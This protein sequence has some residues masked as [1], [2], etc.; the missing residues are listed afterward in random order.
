MTHAEPL[1]V[2]LAVGG[3]IGTATYCLG[4]VVRAVVRARQAQRRRR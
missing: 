4:R 2:Q 3:S 1:W